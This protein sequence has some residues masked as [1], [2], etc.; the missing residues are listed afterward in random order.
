MWKEGKDQFTQSDRQK[1]EIT[2]KIQEIPSHQQDDPRARD[3]YKPPTV[4]YDNA[5]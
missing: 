3:T 5:K 2:M 1:A 4:D